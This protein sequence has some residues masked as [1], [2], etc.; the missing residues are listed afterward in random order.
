MRHC[1][2]CPPSSPVRAG[3]GGPGLHVRAGG[4]GSVRDGRRLRGG[5]RAAPHAPGPL[6]WARPLRRHG[7]HGR[8]GAALLHQGGQLQR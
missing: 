5:P 2:V 1:G 4:E 3:E 8:Q 6:L 7:Q